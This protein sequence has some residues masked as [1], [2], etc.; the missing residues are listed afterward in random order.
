[1]YEARLKK[2]E[3]NL[4]PAPQPVGAYV[5]AVMTD[6]YVYTSGQ[7]PFVTG[8]LSYKGKIGSDLSESQGYEAARICVIN[9]LAVV[10]VLIGSLDNIDKIIKVSGYVNS[11]PGFTNQAKVINGASDLLGEIFDQAGRH[12]RSAL[13]VSELPLDAAVEVEMVVKIK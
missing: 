1:M 11:A 6:K 3:I 8:E 9:C 13:G 10:R 2:L 7:L 12:A 5:P 4:P